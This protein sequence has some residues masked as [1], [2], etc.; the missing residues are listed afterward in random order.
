[1][2]LHG[3]KNDGNSIG[4]IVP[5]E[6]AEVNLVASPAELRKIAKFLEYA[7]NGMEVHGK[8]FEHVHLSDKM[9]EFKSAPHFVVINPDA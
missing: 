8:N 7:A 5:Q 2:K 4:E 3:Y 9:A 6:L 1:M